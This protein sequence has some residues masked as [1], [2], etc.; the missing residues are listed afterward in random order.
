VVRSAMDLA[1][2]DL[3]LLRR[4]MG[5]EHWIGRGRDELLAMR[6]VRMHWYRHHFRAVK[7]KYLILKGKQLVDK[8]KKKDGLL[9]E[10]LVSLVQI[11]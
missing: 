4:A 3:M 1:Y 8:V 7:Q 2:R 9:G 6:I 11:W 10:V 5:A